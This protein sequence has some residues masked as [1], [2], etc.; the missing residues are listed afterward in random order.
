MRYGYNINGFSISSLFTTE[1]KVIWKQAREQAVVK[2]K[3]L[4]VSNKTILSSLVRHLKSSKFQI[5]LAIQ[6]LME[7]IFWMKSI[8]VKEDIERLYPINK[9]YTDSKV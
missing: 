2:C 6:K 9:E 8:N 1:Q 7:Y 5:P 4:G 3:K